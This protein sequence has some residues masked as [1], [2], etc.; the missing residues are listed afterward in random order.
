[1]RK[2]VVGILFATALWTSLPRMTHAS[3]E[4]I[5]LLRLPYEQRRGRMLGPFYLSIQSIRAELRENETV[6]ISMRDPERDA[7]IAVLSSTAPRLLTHF[8][9]PAMYV[10]G[11]ASQQNARGNA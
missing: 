9:G 10:L 1:M 3:L 11:C 2:A 6:G 5:S 8:I 4:A 7:G